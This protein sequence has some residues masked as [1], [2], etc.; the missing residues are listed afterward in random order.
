MKRNNIQIQASEESING[1]HLAEIIP[2]TIIQKVYFK[3]KTTN[4]PAT[5][6]QMKSNE[7]INELDIR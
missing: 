3:K 2:A 7:P 4:I 1:R 6:F 5:R